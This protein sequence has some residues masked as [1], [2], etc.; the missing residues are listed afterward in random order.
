M[1]T[2]SARV[3][4]LDQSR[5]FVNEPSFAENIGSSVFQLKEENPAQNFVLQVQPMQNAENQKIEPGGQKDIDVF[6]ND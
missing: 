2:H 5:V 1:R 4:T 3:D 6:T